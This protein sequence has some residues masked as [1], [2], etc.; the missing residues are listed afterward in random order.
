MSS[1]TPASSLLADTSAPPHLLRR[2][3]QD[4]AMAAP[5][6]D[7]PPR[8]GVRRVGRRRA[9]IMQR[10]LTAYRLPLYEA[11]RERLADAGIELTL[12]HGDPTAA[13]ATKRDEGELDWAVRVKN[14]YVQ[15][16]DTMLCWIPTP[17]SVRDAPLVVL[18]QENSIVSN[19]PVL[20]APRRPGRRVAF[21]G[22][23]ANL[24]SRDAHGPR[25]RWKRLWMDRVDWWFAYTETTVALLAGRGIPGGR[26]TCLDNAI[27]TRGFRRELESVPAGDLAALR[28]RHAL[29]DDAPLGVFC[30]SL[31]PDKRLDLLVDACEQVRA[32]VP[33]FHAALIGDGPDMAWLRERVRDLPWI[34][35]TGALRGAPKA[36]WFRAATLVLNP[37]LVGLGILDALV[38]GLPLVTTRGARHSPEIAYLRDGVNGALAGDSA[39]A[40]AQAVAGLLADPARLRAMSEAARVD[41]TRYTIEHMAERFAD[42]IVRAMPVA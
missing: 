26:I 28:A 35:V 7:A 17:R 14:R 15:V 3:S 16:G 38:A 29:P 41:G 24:Q 18:P 12:V 32:R 39:E 21:W 33:G 36:A 9:L 5:V 11:M 6:D 40:F 42:G 13:E 1:W 37:G 20:M 27:D 8:L 34:H 30:G 23:G 4:P 10:R 31:Y 2:A 22:H 25:E 19:Y